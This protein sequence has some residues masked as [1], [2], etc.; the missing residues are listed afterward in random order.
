MITNPLLLLR[1]VPLYFAMHNAWVALGKHMHGNTCICTEEY[2]ETLVSLVHILDVFKSHKLLK[3]H[4]ERMYMQVINHSL[5]LC[6]KGEITHDTIIEKKFMDTRQTDKKQDKAYAPPALNGN[7]GVAHNWF[8]P[9]AKVN[10]IWGKVLL[11]YCNDL[12]KWSGQT[13]FMNFNLMYQFCC[14]PGMASHTM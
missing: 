12:N 11:L 4:L 14:Y 3:Q 1:S 2:A 6:H 5:A 13:E 10:H 7:P 9:F 8:T